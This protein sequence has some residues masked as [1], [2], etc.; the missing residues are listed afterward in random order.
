MKNL[1]ITIATII[2]AFSLTYYVLTNLFETND[3]NS[4]TKTNVVSEQTVN[5][6]NNSTSEE[7]ETTTEALPEEDN[8]D[9]IADGNDML[10]DVTQ[11]LNSQ[12]N[13]RNY[14]EEN[15]NLSSDF[16]PLNEEGEEID[17]DQFL[18]DLTSGD[19]APIKLASGEEMY[20][21][22]ELNDTDSQNKI[23]KSIKLV[24]N[25]SY[26]YYQKLGTPLPE[27]NF[28]D[29]NGSH[30]SSENTKNKVLI[31]TCWYINCKTCIEEFPKLNN[32]YDKYEAYEDVV[33]LSLA[34]DSSDKLKKFLI[35]KTFRYPVIPNQKKY[36]DKK[37]GI[38]Q[39]PTHL[40]VDEEGNIEKMVSSVEELMIALEKIAA[41]DLAEF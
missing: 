10:P 22:Y 9:A 30:F 23:G 17:K 13:W 38:K 20:Q 32:L 25:T 36:M 27:F 40:I 35:K 18:N 12:K 37:L 1:L 4:G 26:S 2:G 33:F 16:I 28:I 21:L 29:L 11:Y 15:I 34:F 14:F 31:L 7:T 19:F 8:S 24:A 3:F 6:S 41:P 39:Y 5:D